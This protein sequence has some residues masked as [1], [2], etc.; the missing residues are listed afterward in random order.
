MCDSDFSALRRWSW[1]DSITEDLDQFLVPQGWLELKLI[2]ANFQGLYPNLLTGHYDADKYSFR[3]TKTQRTKASF[4][5]FAE[6]LFGTNAYQ[7]IT[8]PIPLEN[9]TILRPYELCPA[10]EEQDGKKD[11]PNSEYQK[12]V[13]SP[14]YQ[15]LISD[16]S[17][18]LGFKSSALSSKQIDTLWDICRYEQAWDLHGYSAWCSVF[19]KSQ[20]SLLEYLEDIKYYYKQGYG[21]ELNSNVGCFTIQDMLNHLQSQSQPDVVAYFG[22]STTVQLFL[23]A[24]GIAKDKEPVNAKNFEK[25]KDRQWKTSKIGPF[26]ANFA[27]VKYE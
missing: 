19:T 18:K 23:T 24:F 22:H 9:D 10:W 16:V 12:F 11:D 25:M 6:G 7:N 8:I 13:Q 21:N 14:I 3:H 15:K 2:A 5:A 26:A 27:A 1:N 17:L 20:I 4:Q